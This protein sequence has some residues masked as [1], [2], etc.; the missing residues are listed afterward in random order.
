LNPMTILAC[1]GWLSL[2]RH[3]G[4]IVEF[5][6]A[7]A[8]AGAIAALL[9]SF[10]LTRFL[11]EPERYAEVVAPWA[12]LAGVYQMSTRGDARLLAAVAIGFLLVD[13]LQV[14]A[15]TVLVRHVANRNS[16]FDEVISAVA[17]RVGHDVRFCS[18]NEQ[19]TKFMMSQDWQFAYCLAV[20]QEYCGM[21]LQQAFSTFPLLRRE[22]CQRIVTSYRINACLL[23]R[24]VFETLFDEVPSA[25][26]S[27][28]VA[29]E[30]ARLRLLILDWNPIDEP[31]AAPPPPLS[32]IA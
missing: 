23:D 21:T 25:V 6:G 3:T 13:I 27:I 11:G 16:Q 9:T 22:A 5:G 7:I 29:Y 4:S 20:G 31:T 24:E 2:S 18:N 32:G 30:T 10:R 15:S 12:A 8:V 19:A 26:R 17:S 1:F 28:S 14:Y